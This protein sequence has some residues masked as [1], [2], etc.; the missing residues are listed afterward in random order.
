MVSSTATYNYATTGGDKEIYARFVKRVTVTTARGS[1]FTGTAPTPS[2]TTVDS[3]TT[4][5]ISATIPDG[6]TFGGWTFSG[7]KTFASGYSASSNPCNIIPTTNVTATATYT[8]TAPSITTEL[9]YSAVTLSSS[10]VTASPTI[11]ASSATGS[12]TGLAY[13]YSI[14]TASGTTATEGTDY[15]IDEDTGDV[16]VSKPGKYTISLS[17]TDTAYGVTSSA[18]P[19]SATL[20]VKPATPSADSIQFVVTGF[21]D[22]TTSTTGTTYSNPFKIPIDNGSPLTT[23]FDIRTL[24]PEAKRVSGYTYRWTMREGTFNS[25]SGARTAGSLGYNVY[26][27][28]SASVYDFHDAAIDGTGAVQTVGTVPTSY[29]GTQGS[30]LHVTPNGYYYYQAT[31]YAH[32]NGVDSDARTVYLYYNVI[33]NFLQVTQFNFGDTTDLFDVHRIY[34][35]G[36]SI[37]S[38][39]ANYRAGGSAFDTIFYFSKDNMDYQTL[40]VWSDTSPLN[41]TQDGVTTTYTKTGSNGVTVSPGTA[42]SGATWSTSTS[43]VYTF[44]VANYMPVSGVKYFKAYIADHNTDVAAA[45][46]TLHTTVGTSSSGG[47]RPIYFVDN[48][49]N[50][51][52]DCRVM[53]FFADASNNFYYQTGQ[54]ITDSRTNTYRFYIP[55]NSTKVAFAVVDKNYYILPTLS[56]GNITYTATNNTY[57]KAWTPTID[58]TLTDNLGKNTYKAESFTENTTTHILQYS[59][60]SSDTMTTLD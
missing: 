34:A 31:L 23:N 29:S 1:G 5:S 37:T 53:A 2:S 38:L 25:S 45:R 56:N 21:T 60:N 17:L 27:S 42:A 54:D 28:T 19:T 12:N 55:A 35:T 33:S 48:S 3:G 41:V 50:T 40:N 46:P 11:A 43:L 47:D 36:N 26:G 7:T 52:S 22:S 9:S 14:T 4:V 57:Y 10:S 8:L 15:S 32:C 59:N 30:K 18:T 44:N 39:T 16:T 20:T 13:S 51:F 49:G 24:I 6:F 58:L